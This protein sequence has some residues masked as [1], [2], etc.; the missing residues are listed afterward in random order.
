M[1]TRIKWLNSFGLTLAL[2]AG[3]ALAKDELPSTKSQAGNNS[4]QPV[5]G[6]DS[7][8]STAPSPAA[9]RPQESRPAATSAVPAAD[10]TLSPWAAET[11]KL[12]QSGIKEDVILTFINSAGTF[13]LSAEQI[14]TLTQAGVPKDLI[15]AMMQHDH[16]V[17]TG[18]RQVSPSSAPTSPL[19]LFLADS[20]T[21]AQRSASASQYQ[22]PPQQFLAP[23]PNLF[24]FADDQGNE[25]P[26]TL[27]RSPVRKPYAEK[28]TDPIIMWQIPTIMPNTVCVI[29]RCR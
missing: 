23:L 6:A 3:S 2:A 24:A 27:E 21:P 4:P 26:E 11:L 5:V 15:T 22:A 7:V 14:I 20:P 13:N 17:L 29:P 9:A 25:P 1:K 12:V 28:L 10:Q 19:G 16:D 18:V 8:Q